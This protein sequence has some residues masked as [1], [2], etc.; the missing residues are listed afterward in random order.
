MSAPRCVS[1]VGYI[2]T[3]FLFICVFALPA[4]VVFGQENEQV[5][6]EAQKEAKR[7]SEAEEALRTLNDLLNARRERSDEIKQLKGNL[8]QAKEEASKQELEAAIKKENEK[9]DKLGTQILQ[10]TTGAASSDL[11]D[12]ED[13]PFNLQGEL[14]SLIQPFI[15]MMKDATENAR[16]IEELKETIEEA[17]RRQKVSSRSIERLRFL[18]S[19]EEKNNNAKSVASKHLEST[20][21]DWEAIAKEAVTL[22]ETASQQLTLRLDEDR[23][24]SGSM[25]AYATKFFQERGLNLLLALGAAGFVFLVFEILSRS[26]AWLRRRQGIK[27]N[28]WTRL[29]AL[30]FRVVSTVLAFVVMLIIFNMMND[31]LLLGVASLFALAAA[32]LGITML[33]SIIEQV[34]L[35]LNLGAV[36]EDERIVIDGVPWRVKRLDLYTDL[37]NPVLDGGEFTI[38]VRELVGLHS[39]PS[40]ASEPWFPTKMGDWILYDEAQFGQVVSQTPE[41]VQVKDP[42]GG[43]VTFDASA[44]VEKAPRNLSSGFRMQTEIGLDYRHQKEATNA[45][46]SLFREHMHKGLVAVFGEQSVIRVDVDLLRADDSALIFEVEGVFPGFLAPRYEDVERETAR[47]IID[48]CNKFEWSIPFP[49]LVVHRPAS[50]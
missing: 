32:W 25:A 18:L 45:I 3:A 23:S 26:V 39:R 42:G 20:L 29:M 33:P 4:G 50:S 8:R 31:W 11:K 44:F 47:L 34:T 13:T 36:Q 16:R 1:A 40:G 46:L 37:V 28:F 49:Q 14:E 12:E 21:K 6:K 48:A 22:E 41:L 15:K 7:F 9:L 24:S 10:L 27:R 19:V 17:R 30:T 5:K 38:P 35:L 43:I 2:T